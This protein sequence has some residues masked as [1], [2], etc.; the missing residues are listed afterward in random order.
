MLFRTAL[1][2]NAEDIGDNIDDN[3]DEDNVNTNTTAAGKTKKFILQTYLYRL[4]VSKTSPAVQTNPWLLETPCEIRQ[5]AVRDLVKA[6]FSA[7][8]KYEKDK[9]PFKLKYKSKK[10]SDTETISILKRAWNTNGAY[11]ILNE[12]KEQTNDPPRSP[13]PFALPL[14]P[15]IADK[16]TPKAQLRPARSR[17]EKRH[18]RKKK[19]QKK[20]QQRHERQVVLNPTTPE[21][22]AKADRRAKRASA[23][24][25]H[26]LPDE[27]LH[28]SRLVYLRRRGRFYMCI[29]MPLDR[30]Q[31]FSE[32]QAVHK[33]P[34]LIVF[35][36]GVRIFMVGYDPSGKAFLIGTPERLYRRFALLDNL[37]S[38]IA[39]E[40]E[41]RRKKKLRKLASKMRQRTR[42][43]IDEIHRKLA[44]YLCETYNVILLPK[45]DTQRMVC[46]RR[47]GYRRKIRTKTARTMM[48]W[49]HY[50]FRMH[51][52]N[53]AR[54]YPSC[55][56]VIVNEAYTS[57]TCGRC[58][59][60]NDKLG[61]NKIFKC[62]SCGLEAH[63]DL[64]AA[65]NILLRYLTENPSL[66][67]PVDVDVTYTGQVME[68]LQF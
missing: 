30:K 68:T 14:A 23:H 51:L 37:M 50:R 21:E 60:I 20:Q 32:N 55:R 38:R 18:Q 62:A 25:K 49:S 45:F 10:R 59:K 15:E 58:G 2:A 26:Q 11:K 5:E 41:P 24:L 56:V 3:N 27:L 53:K 48:T 28:D 67:R 4:V 9:Q 17:Q 65:R 6:Y 34:S 12:I 54:E 13:A 47:G 57:K 29:P 22:K 19:N 16:T 46:R 42:N 33:L 40:K 43:L 8:A 7:L 35:D 36:P 44:K 64:H 39:E 61:G 66:I 63:R 31:A 1:P 52:L